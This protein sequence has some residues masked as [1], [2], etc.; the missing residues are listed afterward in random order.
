MCCKL[1]NFQPVC[2]EETQLI[3][4]FA[5]H[6]TSVQCLN[7]LLKLYHNGIK[8]L[9]LQKCSTNF[10]WIKPARRSTSRNNLNTQYCKCSISNINFSTYTYLVHP[11][12]PAKNYK[13]L[14]GLVLPGKSLGRAMRRLAKGKISRLLLQKI[15]YGMLPLLPTMQESF[16]YCRRH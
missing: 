13:T 7:H 10:S 11:K 14:H 3:E 6:R 9:L 12:K 8:L 15:T 4:H 2:L 16:R 1:S 5:N